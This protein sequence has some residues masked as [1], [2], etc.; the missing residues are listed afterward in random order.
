MLF[1]SLAPSPAD[2][3]CSCALLTILVPPPAPLLSPAAH[4]RRSYKWNQMIGTKTFFFILQ[5]T[6]NKIKQINQKQIKEHQDR[7][8]YRYTLNDFARDIV[9]LVQTGLSEEQVETSLGLHQGVTS[10]LVD[11]FLERDCLKRNPSVSRTFTSSP[12]R[13]SSTNSGSKIP[14][15]D[16]MKGSCLTKALPGSGGIMICTVRASSSR[17]H[18][19]E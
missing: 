2:S 16:A 17:S 4:S 9:L 15:S 8:W 11:K 10:D 14:S 18:C 19:K 13:L 5:G 1:S 6:M 3:C 7:L 12:S